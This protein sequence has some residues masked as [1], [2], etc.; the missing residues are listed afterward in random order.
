MAIYEISQ[1]DYLPGIQL[2]YLKSDLI[3][4]SAKQRLCNLIFPSIHSLSPDYSQKLNL[5][6]IS[7][8]NTSPILF[9]KASAITS[10][11]PAFRSS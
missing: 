1:S 5:P 10:I 6:L 2:L 7:N 9:S 3:F 8:Y 4:P 11:I